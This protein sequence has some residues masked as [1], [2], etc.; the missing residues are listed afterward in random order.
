MTIQIP[1]LAMS[2]KYV[3]QKFNSLNTSEVIASTTE[4]GV[5]SYIAEEIYNAAVGYMYLQRYI[6][7]IDT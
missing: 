3:T 5:H 6:V 4:C 1:S 7:N 2:N